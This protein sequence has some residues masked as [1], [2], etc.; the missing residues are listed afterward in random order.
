MVDISDRSLKQAIKTVTH[1]LKHLNLT[2]NI[3]WSDFFNPQSLSQPRTEKVPDVTLIALHEDFMGKDWFARSG[4]LQQMVRATINQR[5]MIDWNWKFEMFGGTFNNLKIADVKRFIG[6]MSDL[7]EPP[8]GEEQQRGGD[9]FIVGLD[10]GTDPLTSN[11][12]YDTAPFKIWAAMAFYRAAM[13]AG[14]QP[15]DL[16]AFQCKIVN[17]S[18]IH[19]VKNAFPE[20]SWGPIKQRELHARAIQA[21]FRADSDQVLI[22]HRY[23]QREPLLLRGVRL[24]PITRYSPKLWSWIFGL[25]DMRIGSLVPADTKRFETSKIKP[26]YAVA[27]YTK[28]VG[29]HGRDSM[30]RPLG[31]SA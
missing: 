28:R 17:T 27:E 9:R 16:S 31:P 18:C 4:R 23:I 6:D 15:F 29:F 3:L 22:P 14:F 2:Y 21:E 12:C 7:F 11:S 20:L 19:E 13:R 8:H 24:E 26:H 25:H 10:F 5:E 1:E 30:L